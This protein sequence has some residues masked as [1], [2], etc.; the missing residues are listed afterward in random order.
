[1]GM[2]RLEERPGP[3]GGRDFALTRADGRAKDLKPFEQTVLD[4]LL[5]TRDQVL[6]SEMQGSFRAHVPLFRRQLYDAA[7]QAGLFNTSPEAAR[8]RYRGIGIALLV[9]SV[10]GLIVAVNLLG[11][12]VVLAFFPFLSLAVVGVALVLVARVMAQHTRAG[13]LEAARWRAFGRHLKQAEL[14]P[15]S[16]PRL[17]QYLPYSVALGAD[18][19]W[20]GKFTS[21]QRRAPAWY[22]T[23]GGPRGYGRV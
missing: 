11:G 19:E 9:G 14:R 15:D 5:G 13:A 4:A 8:W 21:A 22:G 6:V 3:G 10:I 1:R 18:R 23:S 2:V 20:L 17:E 12:Q 7:V 16:E